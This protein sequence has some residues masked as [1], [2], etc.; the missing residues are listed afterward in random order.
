MRFIYFV[1]EEKVLKIYVLIAILA[2]AL[3]AQWVMFSDGVDTYLYNDQSGDVYVRYKKGGKNYEDAFIKMPA[4]IVPK[5]E[6]RAKSKR[7]SIADKTTESSKK[8][9]LEAIQKSQE[10]LRQS[11]DSSSLLE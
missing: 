11:I 8:Q 3:C 1:C 10:L 4:G 9:N 2:Q 5:V 7:E 6:S